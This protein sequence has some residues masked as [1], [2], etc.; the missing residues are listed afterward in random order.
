[1]R[2]KE[3]E[4]FSY[5]VS[6]DL[7]APLRH[8]GGFVEM[9]REEAASVL[10]DKGRQHLLVITESTNQMGRLI[11]NLLDF[12]RM[13]R[14]E[15]RKTQ[16]N[17]GDVV[18]EV[19]GEIRR[20]TEGRQVEWEIDPLPVVTGDRSMLKQVW[21]NLISNAVKYTRSRDRA[22]IQIR[23]AGND[24]EQWLFSVQDNGAGFDMRYADN[25]GPLRVGL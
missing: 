6:H 10:S 18:K 15:L 17:T 5:S 14:V 20:E 11:D 24:G 19:V 12:S 21:V 8:I 13:G 7:R 1:M 16:V 9:L 3:L 4:A 23:C 22:R 2:L 25:L